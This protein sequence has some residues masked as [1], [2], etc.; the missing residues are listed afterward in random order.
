MA[1]G[2]LPLTFAGLSQVFPGPTI[3]SVLFTTTEKRSF[4]TAASAQI[5]P[6]AADLT[7]FAPAAISVRWPI[8][9][10]FKRKP[11]WREGSRL[12]SISSVRLGESP[13]PGELTAFELFMF[14]S[15]SSSHYFDVP[16]NSSPVK[17]VHP[18]DF[19]GQVLPSGVNIGFTS[20][21]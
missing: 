1:R 8:T 9:R 6:A 20:E 12:A 15:Q 4:L 14:D 7:S 13:S 19:T 3:C 18:V 10:K 16:W 21:K 11:S 5:Q 2:L 17:P